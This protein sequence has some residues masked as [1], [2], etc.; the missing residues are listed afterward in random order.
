MAGITQQELDRL[1]VP[2][3]QLEDLYPLSPMQSGM[4]FHSVFDADA[5]IYLNQ[6]RID[7]EGLDVK[8]FKA[9]WQAAMDRHDVLRQFP[10]PAGALRPPARY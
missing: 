7:I 5:G 3:A 9:A 10:A 4:L 1:P 8:R 6:L 2:S